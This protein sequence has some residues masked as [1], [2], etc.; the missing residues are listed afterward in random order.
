MFTDPYQYYG[1]LSDE[2]LRAMRLVVDTGLHV[3]GWSRED[4]IDYMLENSSM[5]ESDVISE[6]ERYIAIPSQ[7]LGYKIGQLKIS[8]LRQRAENKLGNRFDV[9]K[10]HT[11]VLKDGSLPLDVLDAKINRWIASQT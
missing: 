8:E 1:R 11:E 3:K 5:A 7:A 6:A 2:M 4:V 9:K 10:F